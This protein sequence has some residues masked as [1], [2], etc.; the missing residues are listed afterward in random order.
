[1]ITNTYTGDQYIGI[2]AKNVSGVFKTLKRRM[3]KHVQRALSE[4]KDW[5]LCE[6][7]RNWGSEAFTFGFVESIRGRK[8]AHQRERQLINQYQ[9]SLNTF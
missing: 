1:V 7:I 5:A 3:Q 9:P 6:N 8:A 4:S 2:T